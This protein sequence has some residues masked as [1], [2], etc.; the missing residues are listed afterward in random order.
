MNSTDEN[1]QLVTDRDH[2]L[3]TD[4][5][6]NYNNN[7]NN[8]NNNLMKPHKTLSSFLLESDFHDSIQLVRKVKSI[9]SG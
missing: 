9:S 2:T 3:N 6:I 8:N 7:N 1:T 4:N 5:I